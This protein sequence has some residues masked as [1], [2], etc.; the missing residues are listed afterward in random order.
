MSKDVKKSGLTELRH[1]PTMCRGTE[2]N[3]EK[4]VR[5]ADFQAKNQ[6]WDLLN[7][8]SEC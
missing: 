5:L 4:I 6:T 2:D 7:M 8:K 1:Y 3:Q